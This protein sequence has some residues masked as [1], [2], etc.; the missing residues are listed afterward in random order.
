M[1]VDL[2]MVAGSM[3]SKRCVFMEKDERLEK[4]LDA[5]I[6]K[7]VMYVCFTLFIIVSVLFGMG[8]LQM[9]IILAS[10]ASAV[11]FAK[12]NTDRKNTEETRLPRS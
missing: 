4:E 12:A 7:L 3:D 8:L 9:T 1:V 5:K 10:I 11:H 2:E 6:A